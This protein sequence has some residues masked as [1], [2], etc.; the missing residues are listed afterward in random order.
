MTLRTARTVATA[1]LRSSSSPM[2]FGLMSG[3]DVGSLSASRT[4]PR[5][6][7]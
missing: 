1:A 6:F 2:K 4:Q 7:G 5:L 3:I